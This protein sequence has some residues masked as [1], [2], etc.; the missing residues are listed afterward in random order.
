MWFIHNFYDVIVKPGFIT[1]WQSCPCSHSSKNQKGIFMIFLIY[2]TRVQKFKRCLKELFRP[3]FNN[4]L[5]YFTSLYSTLLYSTLLYS[6]LLYSTL[7]YSTL[8]YSTLLYSTLLYSTLSYTTLLY[9]IQLCSNKNWKDNSSWISY[10]WMN[11]I[12]RTINTVF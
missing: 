2:G 5:L 3:R 4:I 9:I 8:L 1:L 6:T 12:W 10:A 7:L 11:P